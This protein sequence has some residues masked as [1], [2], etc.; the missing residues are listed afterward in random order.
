MKVFYITMQFPAPSETFAATDVRALRRV[1]ADVS[2]HSLRSAHD[3]TNRLMRER[4]TTGVSVSHNNFFNTIIGLLECLR[5]PKVTA[6]LVSWLV[7]TLY[8]Q[9]SKLWTSIVLVPR[10]MQLFA[11]IE[12]ERPDVV[13]LFWG[14]YP[15]MVGYLVKE[16]LPQTVLS[17]FL[18]AYDLVQRYGGSA[19]VA[20]AA[21]AV[22]THAQINVQDIEALGVS[23]ER[24]QVVYRGTDLSAVKSLEKSPYKSPRRIVS[25]SRLIPAKGVDN[26]I[27]TF[28][29][30]V[31]K[32]PDASLTILGDGGQRDNLEA[33]VASLGLEQSVTFLGHVSQETVLAELDMAEVFLFLSSKSSERLPNVVKEAMSCKCLCI[34]TETPGIEELLRD[35]EH[36]F[37]VRV[38]RPLEAAEILDDAFAGRIDT[39]AIVEAAYRHVNEAFDVDSLMIRYYN[40]WKTLRDEKRGSS[41]NDKQGQS[42]RSLFGSFRTRPD[43]RA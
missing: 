33:L 38:E 41:V 36:G 23:P 28:E 43:D 37:I 3:D 42:P 11:Q 8:R 30:I 40:T 13:H 18:G 6:G 5:H 21:D 9:R 12:R 7:K 14:H 34:V 22:W 16:H 31:K 39:T 29:K 24:L 15:A 4:K 10:V 1:G 20:R 35:K 26:V 32:W 27:Y 17:V 19:P 2:V 25:A